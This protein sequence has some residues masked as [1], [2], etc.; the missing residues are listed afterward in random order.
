MGGVTGLSKVFF[1]GFA[2]RPTAPCVTCI[3]DDETQGVQRGRC[4]TSTSTMVAIEVSTAL[5]ISFCL[6]M[7]LW[8][9]C[10]NKSGYLAGPRLAVYEVRWCM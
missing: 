4:C 2:V 8:K 6:G 3:A 5:V 7:E 1:N 10:A 9:E